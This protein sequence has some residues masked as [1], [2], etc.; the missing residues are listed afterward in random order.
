MRWNQRSPYQTAKTSAAS[1]ISLVIESTAGLYGARP[2]AV[3][4]AASGRPPPR[5]RRGRCRPL[6]YRLG[7]PDF[8]LAADQLAIEMPGRMPEH[9]HHDDEADQERQRA[10]HQ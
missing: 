3:K 6:A 8:A 1:A 5:A 9:R 10:Q 2:L 4:R 7:R